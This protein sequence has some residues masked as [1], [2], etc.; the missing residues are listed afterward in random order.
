[1]PHDLEARSVE[2]DVYPWL[3]AMWIVW[4][5]SSF[6]RTGQ[7][8]ASPILHAATEKE[9]EEEEEEEKNIEGQ[10]PGAFPGEGL[11]CKNPYWSTYF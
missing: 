6:P 7:M 11:S 10:I 2:E 1:M 3:L 5:G 8:I 4:R 9:E